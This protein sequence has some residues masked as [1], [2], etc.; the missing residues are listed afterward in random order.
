M[1]PILITPLDQAV[2]AR[3]R[4][5]PSSY[6]GVVTS[7]PTLGSRTISSII[8]AHAYSTL[9]RTRLFYSFFLHMPFLLFFLHTLFLL[10]FCTCPSSLIFAH[11]F[12]SLFLQTPFLVSS[13]HTFSSLLSWKLVEVLIVQHYIGS[14]FSPCPSTRDRRCLSPFAFK[15]RFWPTLWNLSLFLLMKSLWIKIWSE[16]DEATL[17][18]KSSVCVCVCARSD[19]IISG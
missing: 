13:L 9:F 11:I 7:P 3:R 10:F 19:Y 16:F 12:S 8:F 5:G 1:L 4:R 14:G 15:H 6:A 2:V 18:V 17:I